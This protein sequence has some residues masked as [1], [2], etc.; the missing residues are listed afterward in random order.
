VSLCVITSVA[1]L[2]ADLLA[3]IGDGGTRRHLILLAR[4]AKGVVL[5]KAARACI[6]DDRGLGPSLLPIAFEGDVE[7]R[8]AVMRALVVAPDARLQPLLVAAIDDPDEAVRHNAIRTLGIVGYR[9]PG[10]RPHLPKQ[11]RFR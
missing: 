5:A 10:P 11:R 1:V 6:R 3:R 4:S 9:G 7:A 2:A 8:R